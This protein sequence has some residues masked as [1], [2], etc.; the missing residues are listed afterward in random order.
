MKNETSKL[1]YLCPTVT[2][3]SSS[4]CAILCTSENGLQDYNLDTEEEL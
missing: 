2:V 1:D 3:V 4:L